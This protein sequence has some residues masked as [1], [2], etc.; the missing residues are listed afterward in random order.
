VR[1]GGPTRFLGCPRA[2]VTAVLEILIGPD[3]DDLIQCTHVCVP[4]GS[5]LG[6]FKAYR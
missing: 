2:N 6:V 1:L 3:M 5:E 4:E